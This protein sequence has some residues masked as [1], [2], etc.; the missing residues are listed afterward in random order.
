MSNDTVSRQMYPT[1]GRNSVAR[2]NVIDEAHV[3]R[4]EIEGRF[5][6]EAVIQ[7]SI[8]WLTAL[9]EDPSRTFTTD[10]SE[11]TG[12]DTAG[13]R[14]LRKMQKHGTCLGAR[15]PRSLVFLHEVSEPASTGPTLVYK[16]KDPGIDLRDE[17]KKSPVSAGAARAVAAGE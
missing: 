8:C 2:I 4:I 5:A 10:I 1:A 7:A 11:L 9:R 17:R 6:G 3:F 16:A 13:L 15:T 12:Y 14:L